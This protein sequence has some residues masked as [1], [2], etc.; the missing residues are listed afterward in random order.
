M[1]T[2]RR[3]LLNKGEVLESLRQ[4]RHDWRLRSKQVR[5]RDLGQQIY[6][7]FRLTADLKESLV[8]DALIELA[9]QLIQDERANRQAA[10][11]RAAAAG[12]TAGPFQD[13]LTHFAEICAA[14]PPN[15]ALPGGLGGTDNTVYVETFDVDFGLLRKGFEYLRTFG[16]GALRNA[17]ALE[18][19]HALCLRLGGKPGETPRQILRRA[20][21]DAD[22]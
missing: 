18:G 11:E 8:L 9:R 20:G 12:A 10:R 15:Y 14:C 21:Y 2:S 3:V 1:A 5:A 16:L 4:A 19:L 7:E 6:D 17:N 13:E 22:D